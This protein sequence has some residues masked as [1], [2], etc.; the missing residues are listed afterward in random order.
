MCVK[1]EESDICCVLCYR[2]VS[3]C[4]VRSLISAVCCITGLCVCEV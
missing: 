4:S 3:V 2:A 1:C